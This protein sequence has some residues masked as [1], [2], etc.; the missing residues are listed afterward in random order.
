MITAL[1]PATQLA[2]AP[3]GGSGVGDG[4]AELEIEIDALR[5]HYHRRGDASCSSLQQSIPLR[6]QSEQRFGTQLGNLIDS[7]LKG[8]L[9]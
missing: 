2:P 5:N 6:K 9:H 8:L 7:G 4:W 1:R 3:L